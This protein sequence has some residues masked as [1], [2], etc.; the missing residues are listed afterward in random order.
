ML[1]D[2][3]LILIQNALEYTL[4]H[5]GECKIFIVLTNSKVDVITKDE[6]FKDL[7]QYFLEPENLSVKVSLS[8]RLALNVKTIKYLHELEDKACWFFIDDEPIYGPSIKSQTAA[9]VVNELIQELQD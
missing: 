3:F 8:Q 5:L 6:L 1:V 9:R 7:H 4:A 2:L